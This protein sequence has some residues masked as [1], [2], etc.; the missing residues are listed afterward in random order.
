MNQSIHANVPIVRQRNRLSLQD[1]KD[2]VYNFY[3]F[4]KDA[5]DNDFRVIAKD[6]AIKAFLK[7]RNQSQPLENFDENAEI[8][9]VTKWIEAERRAEYVDWNGINNLSSMVCRWEKDVVVQLN[10]ILGHRDFRCAELNNIVKRIPSHKE[11]PNLKEFGVIACKQIPAGTFLGY[12]TGECITPEQVRH[13]HIFKYENLFSIGKGQFIFANDFL[14]CFGRYYKRSLAA[15]NVC[16]RRLSWTDPQKA[17]CFITTKFV[18]KGEEFFIPFGCESWEDVDDKRLVSD[19]FRR[20]SNQLMNKI[21]H[22]YQPQDEAMYTYQEVQ[23]LSDI[24][25]NGN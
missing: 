9:A 3:Q 14:S 13:G 11:S 5:G 8:F 23:T 10:R 1:K 24:F 4:L 18:D 19:N 7:H 15:H 16:V 20:V 12:F 21:P 6:L 17:L 2:V 22:G 25:G